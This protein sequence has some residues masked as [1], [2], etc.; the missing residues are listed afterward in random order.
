MRQALKVDPS[1]EDAKN[2]L[3]RLSK[4]VRKGR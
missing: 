1:Y 3:A 4:P 2:E